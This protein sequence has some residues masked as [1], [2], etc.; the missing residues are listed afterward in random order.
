MYTT[1]EF[2]ASLQADQHPDIISVILS[3]EGMNWAVAALVGSHRRLAESIVNVDASAEAHT[4]A[5]L[6]HDL[7]PA[8]TAW[9]VLEQ[10]SV[11]HFN[12]SGC[13]K[14]RSG[15]LS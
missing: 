3:S 6:L 5:A 1:A 9:P 11:A 4:K 12:R 10:R 8:A 14:C 13:A 2:D 7:E 15:G